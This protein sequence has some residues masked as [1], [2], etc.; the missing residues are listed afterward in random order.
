MSEYPILMRSRFRSANIPMPYAGMYLDSVS[1]YLG[2]Q[3]PERAVERFV[4]HVRD[5][6]CVRASEDPRLCGLGLWISGPKATLVSAAILQE[7]LL[8]QCIESALFVDAYEYTE[9][10]KPDRAEDYESRIFSDVVV[11]T[12]IVGLSD[13]SKN[14]VYHLTRERYWKGLPTIIADKNPWS[15]FQNLVYEDCVAQVLLKGA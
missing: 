7:L 2:R 5:G 12:G 11:L 14:I 15:D 3:A 1:E 6:K 10:K 13:W 9:S 8:D 4:E